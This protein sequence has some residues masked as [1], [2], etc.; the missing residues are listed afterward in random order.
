[1]EIN[2]NNQLQLGIA[3][4]ERNIERVKILLKYTTPSY[5]TLNE[6]TFKALKDKRYTKI[7]DLLLEK[8][9]PTTRM[10]QQADHF[11]DRDMLKKFAQKENSIEN[12]IRLFFYLRNKNELFKICKTHK[13][14]HELLDE[15]RMHT[16]FNPCSE[17]LFNEISQNQYTT[18]N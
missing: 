6:A 8:A 3:I 2:Q 4:Y 12:Q 14:T 10:I 1:M 17:D 11:S 18:S 9:I 15:F 16:Q 13:L 5:D 7:I